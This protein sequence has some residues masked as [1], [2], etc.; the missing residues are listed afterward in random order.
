M[1]LQFIKENL[2]L[3]EL[4]NELLNTD[5]AETASEILLEYSQKNNVDY[6]D[7]QEVLAT[8]YNCG[9]CNSCEIYFGEN[10]WSSNTED[11]IH[12]A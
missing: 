5:E 10:M 8:D 3:K 2:N 7:V 4:A 11:C 1:S 12:C 9:M 6:G